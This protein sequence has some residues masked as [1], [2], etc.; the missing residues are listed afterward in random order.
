MARG[1]TSGPIAATVAG[2]CSIVALAA[3][4]TPAQAA[5]VKP[6]TKADDL[7]NNGNCTL[8]EAVVAT[9]T[10][11]PRD[12]CPAGNGADKIK[13]KKGVYKLTVTPTDDVDSLD[14]DLDV[15]DTD[16]V[17][18]LGVP[19]KT[20]VK[21]DGIERVFEIRQNADAAFRF[22]KITGGGPFSLG[23]GILVTAGATLDLADSTVSANKGNGGGGI[24]V[25]GGTLD[26]TR[27]TVTG[28]EA[29]TQTGTDTFDGGGIQLSA[30]TATI[31]ESA[32]TGNTAADEGGGV[33]VEGSVASLT[34]TTVSGNIANSTGSNGGGG[35]QV[36]GPSASL[37]LT[38][39]TVA[40]NTAEFGG[41][42]H[43]FN[44][45]AAAIGTILADNTA[46]ASGHDCGGP[47]GLSSSGY[48]LIESSSCTVT[49]PAT[50]DLN[51]VDPKLRPLRDNGGPTKTQALKTNSPAANAAERPGGPE[52][53]QR[54]TERA[55]G[56]TFA[57]TA[58]SGQYAGTAIRRL[59]RGLADALGA[60]S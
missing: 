7:A 17:K 57:L 36:L 11:A 15:T 20:T 45:G 21:G 4:G 9:N 35:I 28:N 56:R 32:I 39:A 40:R 49:G 14:G 31:T 27:T 37:S 52:T 44:A 59:R 10:D 18:V 23:G 16:G 26:M 8:R 19:G 50:M 58:R 43:T 25:G 5:V 33:M 38:N 30:A 1:K 3:A 6:D 22:L 55:L 2:A 41:G 34:N 13:L 29:V 47:G 42:V 54:G 24:S 53:D 51:G 48:N 46:T 12:D 60:P